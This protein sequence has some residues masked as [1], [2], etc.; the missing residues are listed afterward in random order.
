MRLPDWELGKLV[1]KVK[2]LAH[3]TYYG[4]ISFRGHDLF[5]ESIV[6]IYRYV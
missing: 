5:L 3:L 6:Q 1:S 2:Q 4:R